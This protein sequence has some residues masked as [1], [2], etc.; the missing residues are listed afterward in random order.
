MSYTELTGRRW[1][2][3]NLLET[4]FISR[5]VALVIFVICLRVRFELCDR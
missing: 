3:Y 2:Q 1:A 5:I 4:S